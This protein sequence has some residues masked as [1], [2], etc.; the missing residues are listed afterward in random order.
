MF[1]AR[2]DMGVSGHDDVCLTDFGLFES[3]ASHNAPSRALPSTF[4]QRLQATEE[5]IGCMQPY[6]ANPGSRPDSRFGQPAVFGGEQVSL[7]PMAEY[8]PHA[9]C[10][11]R[12]L[13]QSAIG[14]SGHQIMVAMDVG[15]ARSLEAPCN[16]DVFCTRCPK[17]ASWIAKG[18]TSKRFPDITEQD[19]AFEVVLQEIEEPEKV[20]IVVSE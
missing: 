5:C 14:A 10:M 6:A 12:E 13:F 1:C 19:N 15:V 2:G 3:P 20:V 17:L 7:V 9:I 16:F 11:N 18:S 4:S 8:Q